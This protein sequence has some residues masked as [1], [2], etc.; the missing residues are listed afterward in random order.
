MKFLVRLQPHV[1]DKELKQFRHLKGPPS[2]SHQLLIQVG[3]LPLPFPPI[4]TQANRLSRR[5][6]CFCRKYPLAFVNWR[7]TNATSPSAN[8]LRRHKDKEACTGSWVSPGDQY[9]SLPSSVLA[10]IGMGPLGPDAA[11]GTFPD[12]L[13][14]KAFCGIDRPIRQTTSGLLRNFQVVYL[15]SHATCTWRNYTKSKN[16][17][18]PEFTRGVRWFEGPQIG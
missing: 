3:A 16:N 18:R 13:G 8:A 1:P 17:T 9:P 5:N 4:P 7:T 6:I 11:F 15:D 2:I 14:K 10:K 12:I